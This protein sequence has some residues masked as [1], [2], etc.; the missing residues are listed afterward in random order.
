MSLDQRIIKIVH[1]LVSY[2]KA[3]TS[4]EIANIIGMSSRTVRETIQQYKDDLRMIGIEIESHFKKGYS[5]H[6]KDQYQDNWQILLEENKSI[7]P[8][9]TDDKIAYIM[10]RF[11]LENDYIKLDDLCDELWISRSTMNRL[12]KD[13]RKK[14]AQYHLEIIS[15]PSYGLKLEGNEMNKRICF[16]RDCI[17]KRKNHLEHFMEEYHIDPQNCQFIKQVIVKKLK[18]YNYKLTD[19]GFQN[20]IIHLLVAI[21]R[22]DEKKTIT[23]Y[24]TQIDNVGIEYL[25]AYDI[26]EELQNHF[27]IVFPKEEVEYVRIHLYGKKLTQL[28]GENAKISKEMEQMIQ[29]INNQIYEKLGYDF[30]KDFELFTLL[31]LHMMPLMVRIQ[32][33]LDMPNPILKDIKLRMSEAF[34]CAVIASHVIQD[35]YSKPIAEGE[36]G[37]L[38]LHYSMAIERLHEKKNIKNIVIVC[39]S[40]MGTSSLLKKRLMKKF[41]IDE[42]HIMICDSQTIQSLSLTCIDYIISTVKLDIEL[43]KPIIYMENIFDDISLE[44]IQKPKSLKPFIKKEFV[45][46]QQSFQTKEAILKNMCEKIEKKYSFSFQQLIDERE[47]LSSTEVGNLVAM[48]HPSSLCTDQSI[49]MIMTLKKSVL[50]KNNYVKYIF[51]ISGNKNSKEES[52]FINEN[53]IDLIMDIQWLQELDKI[54]TYEELMTIL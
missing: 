27:S 22:I 39:S 36:L 1:L 8:S 4:H 6:I 5:I 21:K 29:K 38:A 20:L 52:E 51:L 42:S 11:I 41:H 45:S 54:S 35:E 14:F 47:A 32:Y 18:K 40:G 23:S 34:E 31:A 15:K 3:M 17:K 53:M 44:T 46:F 30:E 2:K 19:I 50:W 12:F 7:I 9:E 49:I 16:V 43:D 13:V 24:P 25:L 28:D 33:G 48:P 37:Y 26:V 10:H